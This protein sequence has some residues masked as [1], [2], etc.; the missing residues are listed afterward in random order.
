MPRSGAVDLAMGGEILFYAFL[1]VVFH[2]SLLPKGLT[3]RIGKSP[4]D[5]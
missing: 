3:L 1:G 5:I 2:L 4:G